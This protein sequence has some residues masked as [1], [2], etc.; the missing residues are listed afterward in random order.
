MTWEF[1][2]VHTTNK[3]IKFRSGWI[4]FIFLVCIVLITILIGVYIT[5]YED[6]MLKSDRIESAVTFKVYGTLK[7]NFSREEFKDRVNVSH[8][9][10]NR[11]WDAK[12][13]VDIQQSEVFIMTNVIIQSGQKYSTCAED[14]EVENAICEPNKANSCSLLGGFNGKGGNG[15]P[16]GNCIQNNFTNYTKVHTCEI[17][18]WCPI[19]YRDEL[20]LKNDTSLLRATEDSIVIISN[21]VNF[22]EFNFPARNVEN[23]RRCDWKDPSC[24]IRPLGYLIREAHM[25]KNYDDVFK[26]GAVLKVEIRWEC[27]LNTLGDMCKL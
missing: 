25:N 24:P 12:D 3:L 6:A 16:T 1:F 17:V 13:Y 20:P 18:A 21:S 10:Y 27:Y 4:R 23:F 26:Y 22:P 14:P 8:T 11:V 7:T 19:M 15:I 5:A 2:K 9:I